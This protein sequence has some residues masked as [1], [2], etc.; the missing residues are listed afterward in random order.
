MFEALSSK[1]KHVP[2]RN[3]K[4]TYLLKPCLSAG[5]KALLLLHVSPDSPYESLT[6]LRFGTKVCVG[7]VGLAA[8]SL[9]KPG[10]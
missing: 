3:S 8:G 5:G 1:S 10:S 7:C 6:S 9:L 4:L 2:Y